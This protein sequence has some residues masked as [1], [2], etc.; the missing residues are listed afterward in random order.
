[1]PIALT[2]YANLIKRPGDLGVFKDL[3]RMSDVLKVFPV[4]EVGSLTVRGLKWDTLPSTA[5]RKIGGS[6]TESRGTTKP[7]EDFLAIH[8]GRFSSD[9]AYDD[10][11][12]QQMFR[13][14][15]D[16]QWEMF[17]VAMERV[18]MEHVINGSIDDDPDSFNGL[19]K[20]TTDP[21][22]INAACTVDLATGGDSLKILADA[23]S[24]QKFFQDGLDPLLYQM[25]LYNGNSKGVLFMNSTMILAIQAA[26][27]LTGWSINVVD[28]F[29][30]KWLEYRGNLFID[31]GLQRDQATEIITNAYDPGD[32]GA[33]STRIFAVRLT[34]PTDTD[35]PLEALNDPG[36]SGLTLVQ[37]GMM[38]RLGP[39]PS[40]L[41][42][43]LYG[44]E[45]KLGMAHV[46]DTRCIGLL[47][48]FKGAAS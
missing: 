1:M 13:D 45:W 2:D 20:R 10:L 11:K 43:V 15:V 6:Y 34:A 14:P 32:G 8:G 24:A 48:G 7:T 29:E 5:F 46:G 17:E 38:K 21:E 42:Q 30:K 37:A 39:E 26:A 40:E 31:V 9:I 33:D 22:K 3:F 19:Y 47:K 4:V 27:R 41:T 28:M 16:Q 35:D 25:G 44:I 18:L 36:V 12:G 23:A